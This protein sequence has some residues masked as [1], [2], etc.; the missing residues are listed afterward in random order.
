MADLNNSLE[1]RHGQQTLNREEFPAPDRN[2]T[3][4][5]QRNILD[6]RGSKNQGPDDFIL[7]EI[8]SKNGGSMSI[9]ELAVKNQKQRH[10]NSMGMRKDPS[11][12][13]LSTLENNDNNVFSSITS[14]NLLNAQKT[15]QKM[16]KDAQLLA[17]RIALLKQEEMRTWKKIEET[18]KRT[19]DILILKSKNYEKLTQ[20][21]NDLQEEQNNLRG[22]QE[23]N[24]E[25]AKR[26]KEER[27]KTE[28]DVY[29]MKRD[30][31]IKIKKL[32]KKNEK[33][34]DKFLNRVQSE[35][36]LRGQIIK[37]SEQYAK[38][39]KEA[40]D[41]KHLNDVKQFYDDRVKKEEKTISKKEREILQM[42]ALEMELIK[43]LQNTQNLQ[44]TAYSDLEKALM[45]Q[46]VKNDPA[47][48]SQFQLGDYISAAQQ[49]KKKK[50]KKRSQS[51]VKKEFQ[52]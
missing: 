10:S 14:L 5:S 52:L 50:R 45:L 15:R 18:K 6:T 26:R 23:M 42:E 21:Q 33:K 12:P 38:L 8:S 46:T 41:R 2:Y 13:R 34:K 37:Q 35:N 16:E 22:S 24:Y 17:N 51:N 40:Q 19:T 39:K 43:N 7:P 9:Q 36:L 49:D 47:I 25:D 3:S 30:Q 11:R 1:V 29:M 20:H 32:T 27:K 48:M 31:A 28:T 4:N 44:K